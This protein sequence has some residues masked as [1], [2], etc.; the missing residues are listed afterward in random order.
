M[1]S[2]FG[3]HP[4]ELCLIFSTVLEFVYNSHHHCLES[5]NQPFLLPQ[6][7]ERYAQIIHNRG[8]PLQNCFGFVDGT[9]CRIARPQNH[10][11]AV[12]NGHK[13]VHGIKFQSVV[14]PNGLIANLVGPFEG[15]RHDSTMLHE[16][17]ML[18]E[19]QRVAWAN[20]EPLCLY[21][22]PA[23]PLGIHLQAPFRDALLTPQMQRF[24]EAMSEVRVSVEWM[25]ET[26]T[27]YY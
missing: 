14:V 3:R 23:Y 19:L 4:T 13:R 5:W 12:Y 18:R 22:D 21:G 6:V 24:N 17:R 16:S 15:R 10:Q 11:R 25:F 26:V 1:V 8:A 2:R 9:L 7:L 27:N 20:G